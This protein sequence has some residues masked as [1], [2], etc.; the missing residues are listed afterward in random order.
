MNNRYLVVMLAVVSSSIFSMDNDLMDCIETLGDVTIGQKRSRADKP[1]KSKKKQRLE[2]EETTDYEHDVSSF[3]NDL[4]VELDENDH[5]DDELQ[6]EI[7]IRHCKPALYFH[8][9]ENSAQ[10]LPKLGAMLTAQTL[11]VPVHISSV[12]EGGSINKKS[13]DF[14]KHGFFAKDAV[15]DK[16]I[17]HHTRKITHLPEAFLQNLKEDVPHDLFVPFENNGNQLTKITLIPSQKKLGYSN[18]NFEHVLYAT[19]HQ[20]RCSTA[21]SNA[22]S[23]DSQELSLT[24]LELSG[25]GKK[26]KR[27]HSDLS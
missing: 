21:V 9:I 6:A 3:E 22:E 12:H 15:D 27:S 2:V 8:K 16:I 4:T 24:D 25:H 13:F 26:I 1:F 17:N 19:I 7:A 10:L 5:F 23:S 11:M 20:F 14:A 18:V